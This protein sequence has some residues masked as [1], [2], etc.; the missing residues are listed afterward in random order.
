MQQLFSYGAVIFLWSSYLLI[1][2]LFTHGAVI[3][4]WSS[5]LLME[6]LFTYA[7][8]IFLWSSYLLMEQLFPYGAVIYL[9][10][11]YLLME[12]LLVCQ[13]EE[14]HNQLYSRLNPCYYL[15]DVKQMPSLGFNGQ[16]SATTHLQ[17]LCFCQQLQRESF[18]CKG[19]RV[20][21]LGFADS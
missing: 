12:Q 10:S 21:S 17:G 16:F 3:Y 1:E 8:V 18:A 6:Q 9:W 2:Q 4:L 11:S 15:P 5:S 19:S 13:S 14:H 20:E 7:A